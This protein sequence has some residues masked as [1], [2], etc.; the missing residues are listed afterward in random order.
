MFFSV[1]LDVHI[2]TLVDFVVVV[3]VAVGG[4][5]DNYA[6]DASD[7]AS[8]EHDDAILIGASRGLATNEITSSSIETSLGKD[9]NAI[10]KDESTNI[11]RGDNDHRLLQ[12]N[13]ENASD[14][15]NAADEQ[16][17]IQILS[18]K[19]RRVTDKAENPQSQRETPETSQQENT[20]LHETDENET[21][22]DA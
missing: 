21:H 4:K 16:P 9:V 5:L 3:T 11:R 10:E 15:C 19:G 17:L 13:C 2:A 18:N 8:T 20:H 1:D 7:N 14:E 22:N 12:H 6:N